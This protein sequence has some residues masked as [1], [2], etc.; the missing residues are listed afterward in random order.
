MTVE[1]Q[2]FYPPATLGY[3]VRAHSDSGPYQV[4]HCGRPVGPLYPTAHEAVA[5]TIGRKCADDFFAA[6][7]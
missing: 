7:N 4:L 6:R 2:Y 5:A 1:I 3:G